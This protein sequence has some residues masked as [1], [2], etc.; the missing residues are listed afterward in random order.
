MPRRPRLRVAQ[1][2]TLELLAV[3]MLNWPSLTVTPIRLALAAYLSSSRSSSGN[4]SLN[5]TYAPLPSSLNPH[6][7]DPSGIA[8]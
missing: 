8:S 1:R 6:L 3:R 5:A 7:V 2:A 4:V